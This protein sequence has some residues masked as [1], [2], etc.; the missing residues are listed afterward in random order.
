LPRHREHDHPRDRGEH[1]ED[2]DAA[3]DEH[4]AIHDDMYYIYFSFKAV[5]S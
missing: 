4:S 3:D 1:R 2:D 5:R